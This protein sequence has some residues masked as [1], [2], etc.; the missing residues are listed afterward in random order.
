MIVKLMS[1]LVRV[2][3]AKISVIAHK[4]IFMVNSIK[5]R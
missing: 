1:R 5:Y 3:E 2:Y 4:I